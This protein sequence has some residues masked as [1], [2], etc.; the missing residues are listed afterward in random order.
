LFLNPKSGHRAGFP[1]I[2]EPVPGHSDDALSGCI[3]RPPQ[4]IEIGLD[5]LNPIGYKA[6]MDML[7]L[8]RDYGDKLVLHSEYGQFGHLPPDSGGS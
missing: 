5:A 2:G 7:A 8:K 3:K 4:L 1:V 6:G